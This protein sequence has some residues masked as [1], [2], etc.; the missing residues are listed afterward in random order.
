M[1]F[2]YKFE[3]TNGFNLYSFGK[4]T[5]RYQDVFV[6]H[7]RYYEGIKL[8]GVEVYDSREGYDEAKQL[9]IKTRNADPLYLTTY[10]KK[11]KKV[12]SVE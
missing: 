6:V 10:L 11:L 4:D 8:K 1:Y 12:S 5:N 2:L 9:T 7:K 3:L